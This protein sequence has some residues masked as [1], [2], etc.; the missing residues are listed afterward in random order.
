[1]GQRTTENDSEK[2]QS[3]SNSHT[4]N[5]PR[6]NLHD[7]SA[8]TEASRFSMRL[9]SGFLPSSSLVPTLNFGLTGRVQSSAFLLFSANTLCHLS[10]LLPFR[11]ELRMGA[12]SR[13]LGEKDAQRQVSGKGV[14]RG[15]GLR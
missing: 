13:P 10:L 15:S 3:W 8:D 2:G 12:F 11:E 14:G 9:D 1:M 4:D 5:G 7:S 6:M